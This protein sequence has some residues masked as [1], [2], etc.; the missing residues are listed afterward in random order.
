[1]K[2]CSL[3]IVALELFGQLSIVVVSLFLA[4]CCLWKVF[5]PV[6]ISMSV[7]FCF[8]VGC[9][10]IERPCCLFEDGLN[11]SLVL[12]Q[13]WERFS[14]VFMENYFCFCVCLRNSAI[15]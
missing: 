11:L 15:A 10:R 2:F 3:H 6:Y 4:T 14:E 8:S 13:V 1:M 5:V 9:V 7:F 12:F